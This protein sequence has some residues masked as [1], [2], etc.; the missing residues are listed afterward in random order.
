MK[1][2]GAKDLGGALNQFDASLTLAFFRQDT[3]VAPTAGLERNQVMW[4]A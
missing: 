3:A 2:F 1:A 4:L